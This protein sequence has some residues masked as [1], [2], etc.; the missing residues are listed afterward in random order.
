MLNPEEPVCASEVRLP[1]PFGKVRSVPLIF[2]KF[3]HVGSEPVAGSSKLEF[4]SKV[5]V[6]GGP[7]T[8]G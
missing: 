4:W 1:M 6:G 5:E 7:F 2:V 8:G 3:Q